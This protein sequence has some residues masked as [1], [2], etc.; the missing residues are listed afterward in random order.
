MNG[1]RRAREYISDLGMIPW[2]LVAACG[3]PAGTGPA[4]SRMWV[5]DPAMRV[6]Y[7][8]HPGRPGGGPP[9]LLLPGFG[10][11]AFHYKRNL[12]QIAQQTGSPVY[13][14]DYLGQGG[15]WPEGAGAGGDHGICYSIDVWIEQT[16]DFLRAVVL[17][18]HERG[19]TGVDEPG[20]LR[21]SST[22]MDL[23]AAVSG[24]GRV[25]GT[26][27]ASSAPVPASS[28]KCEERRSAGP[29]CE[30]RGCHVVGNSVGGLIA[31]HVAAR[32]PSLVAS[33]I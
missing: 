9:V 4:V 13:A 16:R 18:E 11:G 12:A 5:R 10:A 1:G 28:S 33:L 19:D 26:G 31:T 27:R 3:M 17:A 22:G 30:Y 24:A 2:A 15:S 20:V 8:H 25:E 23:A 14:M 21:R 6:H 32:D 29:R 7:E